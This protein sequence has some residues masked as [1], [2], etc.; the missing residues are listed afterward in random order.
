MWTCSLGVPATTEKDPFP[1]VKSAVG[2][3]VIQ[4]E[5]RMGRDGLVEALRRRDVGDPQPHMVD[6][7]V[8]PDGVVVDGLGAVSV[9][10]EQEAAVVVAAVLGPKPG[11]A[12]VA[13]AGLRPHL[14]EVVD[15]RA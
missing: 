13:E 9:G 12:V 15:M 4:A 8:R 7:A 3:V 14:P 6:D 2:R 1:L 11:R 5:A 10:V